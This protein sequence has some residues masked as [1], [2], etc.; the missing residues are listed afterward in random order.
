MLNVLRALADEKEQSI[1]H[2]LE[3]GVSLV[4]DRR[5]TPYAADFMEMRRRLDGA[6]RGTCAAMTPATL[7][8]LLSKK[9][10]RQVD[11]AD[12]A[13][14]RGKSAQSEGTQISLARS[15]AV[16]VGRHARRTRHSCLTAPDRVRR[17]RSLTAAKVLE[18]TTLPRQAQVARH[19]CASVDAAIRPVV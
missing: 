5:G 12:R 4:A 3:R 13:L 18:P 11:S 7:T 15:H 8:E 6:R 1:R 10:S 2:V 17:R 14:P 9:V 16:A 19:V